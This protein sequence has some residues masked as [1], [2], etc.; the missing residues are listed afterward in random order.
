MEFLIDLPVN[1]I[2]SPVNEGGNASM[3]WWIWAVKWTGLELLDLNMA[4]IING[5]VA[6]NVC[7][8]FIYLTFPQT[9]MNLNYT[10]RY[11]RSAQ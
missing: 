2:I 3:N 9:K 4:D 6:M 10:Y 1:L 11:C 7:S 5:S 8:A